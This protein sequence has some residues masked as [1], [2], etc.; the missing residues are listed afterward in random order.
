MK[1]SQ[2]QNILA[3]AQMGSINKAAAVLGISQPNLSLS[4]KSLETELGFEIFKRT[5]H[6]II[7]TEKGQELINYAEEIENS[8]S[9]ITSIPKD[10]PYRTNTLNITHQNFSTAFIA[11]LQLIRTKKLAYRI[12]LKEGSFSDV[13]NDVRSGI[14][15]I[16]FTLLP[17]NP[18]N[19]ISNMMEKNKLIYKPLFRGKLGILAG[20]RH[21]LTSQD[22]ISV[23][24]LLEYPFVMPAF[25]S[26][27][28]V[29]SSIT[30]HIPISKF[31]RIL[32]VR[33]FLSLFTAIVELNACS[34]FVSSDEIDKDASFIYRYIN[35]NKLIGLKFEEDLFME[36][37]W[38]RQSSWKMDSFATEYMKTIYDILKQPFDC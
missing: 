23:E 36:L 5:K 27:D 15:K 6:G 11:Q 38:I 2:V 37:G 9:K 29:Y 16:G 17:S 32:F 4:I 22:K 35:S 14:S 13:I 21:P 8:Y 34:I 20:T 18:D 3:V 24:Q 19:L 30:S 1:I 33:D 25:A 26:D 31:K 12:M 10:T 7:I 28:I